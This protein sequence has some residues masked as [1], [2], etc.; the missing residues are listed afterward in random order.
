VLVEAALVIPLLLMLVVGIA[1]FGFAFRDRLT[2]Q[3]SVRTAAR[4]GSSLG[5]DVQSDYNILQAM[6]SALGSIP[7]ANVETIVVFKSTTANGAVPATCLTGVSQLNSCNV[8]TAAALSAAPTSFGCGAGALDTM[9]CP[10]SRVVDQATGLEYLG[11]YV[12]VKHT[13]LSGF[14]GSR[15]VT[16]KDNVVL[17]LEPK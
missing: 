6:K 11:I 5:N 10:T 2:V 17:R 4:V 16:L 9:W 8:Y 7:L 12:Q 15:Q 14:L 3:T 13:F 1:E